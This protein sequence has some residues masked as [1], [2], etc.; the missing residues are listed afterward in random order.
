MHILIIPS[1]HFLTEKYP[2]GGI[3]QSHQASALYN[4]G[5]QI[6]VVSS[7][8]ITP[9]HLL[10]NYSYPKFEYRQGYPVYR[11]Y[12]RKIYP[13]RWVKPNQGVP[14]HQHFGLELYED[15]KKRFG[16]PDVVHAHGFNYA[17]F[18][19]QAIKAKDNVPYIITEHSSV[20]LTGGLAPDWNALIRASMKNASSVTAVSNML[21]KALE[22]QFRLDSVKVLP[23]LVEPALMNSPLSN[24]RGSTFVFLN[25]AY[26]DRNKNQT[27]L[28]EAFS[29]HFR[30][31]QVHLRIGGSGALERRLKKLAEKLGV[32]DQ[33]FFLG[34]LDRPSVIR[35]MQAAN[36]FVLSSF[37]ETF[38]VVLIES[39]A[40]GTPVIATRC[41]G[42][43]NII[44]NKNGLLV[45]PGNALELGEA[46]VKMMG[47]AAQYHPE[48]LRQEC[49]ARFGEAAFIQNATQLYTEAMRL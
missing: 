42:A 45:E 44:T 46:M 26:L 10:R 35:E 47:T 48:R 25:I 12:V 49:M 31:K 34:F 32:K 24:R 13:E 11:H 14:C 33:V 15:Y 41:G 37:R 8:V 20:F 2:L 16:K 5:H 21:S 22:K 19:A 18:I 4:A 30:G 9:R 6:G 7:A 40:S 17:G 3:F 36:C 39:I 1:Q 28:I 43:N 38:G 23:N 27:M 29:R